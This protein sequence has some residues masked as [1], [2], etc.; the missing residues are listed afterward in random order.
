M[1]A[2]IYGLC[3]NSFN[4]SNQVKRYSRPNERGDCETDGN[5]PS[6]LYGAIKMYLIRFEFQSEVQQPSPI[7]L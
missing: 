2:C 1:E 4:P 7:F 6:G 5:L 3:S